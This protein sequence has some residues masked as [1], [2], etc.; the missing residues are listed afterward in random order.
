MSPGFADALAAGG[1]QHRASFEPGGQVVYRLADGSGHVR[2]ARLKWDALGD[3]FA[4]ELVPVRRRTF[5]LS[6]ALFPAIFLFGMTI[7]Q[8]LPY[9]GVAILAGIFLGPLAIY[10]RHSRKVQEAAARIEA[11][12]ERFPLCPAPPR[13]PR[14]EPRWLQMAFLILVGPPLIIGIIGEIGGPDTFRGTPLVGKGIGPA[15]VVALL[16]IALRLAWP[17]LGPLLARRR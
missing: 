11:E 6:L 10:L 16:L 3:R 15:E 14:R 1:F 13:D 2:L 4:A 5:W 12:L 7:G 8:V 9:A 17:R